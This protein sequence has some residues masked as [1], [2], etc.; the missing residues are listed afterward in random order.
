MIN[1]V[2]RFLAARDQPAITAIAGLLIL[3][4]GL[5][6]YL[7]G[8]EMSFSLFYLLPIAVSAWYGSERLGLVFCLVSAAVWFSVE[9]WSGRVY[10]YAFTAYWN[11][12]VRLAFFVIAS[13]LLTQVRRTLDEERKWANRDG[14]TG[15]TNARAFRERCANYVSLCRRYRHPLTL[16]YIDV[17]NFK[18]VNDEYGHNAGDDLLRRI[19]AVLTNRLRE[20]DVIG[21]LGG[22]EFAVVLPEIDAVQAQTLMRS[23]HEELHAAAQARGWPVGFSIGVALF[24]TLPED[25]A[26]VIARADELMYRV[27]KSGKN[28]IEYATFDERDVA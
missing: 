1:T 14:L 20:T 10:S 15:L 17:D 28:R 5:F 12:F 16:A 2:H 21:R 9:A 18:T 19:A 4:V 23:L 24:R 3:F 25:P 27:K 6:D 7:S 11:A 13:G 26:E 22:D 8:E